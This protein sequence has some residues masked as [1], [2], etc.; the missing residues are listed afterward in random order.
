MKMLGIV[1]GLGPESTIEYYRLLIAG[2]RERRPDGSYPHILINS[3]DVEKVLRLAADG[4]REQLSDY[5]LS[6][7]AQLKNAGAEFAILAANTPHLVFDEL[8]ARSPLPLIS[9]VQATCDYAKAQNYKILGLFGTRST[10]QGGFYQR[11]FAKSG[12]EVIVPGPEE[13]DYVHEKY[14]SELV[15]GLFLPQTRD[16]LLAIAASMKQRHKIDG[17]ILG[18]TELPL[19]LKD[20]SAAGIPLLDTT[21][22]HVTAA[23]ERMLQ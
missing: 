17:L 16:G 13:L 9:I 18:G 15:K 19:L 2:Y 14:V 21:R 6:A 12:I 5:L 11:V 8:A 7:L 4:Q 3:I 20:S 1:G 22:I 10:A 23:L